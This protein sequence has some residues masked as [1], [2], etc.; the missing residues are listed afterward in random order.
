M[1][2]WLTQRAQL[3]DQLEELLAS[4]GPTDTDVAAT[5]AASGVKGYPSSNR[6]S[7]I[8]R[9]LNA[10]V[11]FDHRVA[12]VLVSSH[13]VSI[14]CTHWWVPDV[15]VATPASVRRFIVRFDCLDFADLLAL[16]A[17]P[18]QTYRSESG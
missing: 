6:G 2:K 5:L 4:L 18:G 13:D 14:M 15:V 10:V 16:P 9:Y 7:A 8:P 1:N 11:A 3:R 12:A 17:D